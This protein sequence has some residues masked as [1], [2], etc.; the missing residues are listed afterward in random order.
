MFVMEPLLA[1]NAWAILRKPQATRPS[2]I[3]TVAG[4]R[5]DLSGIFYNPAVM[6]TSRRKEVFAFGEVVGM[7]D[8]K[9]GGLF[10]V[11]PMGMT[12]DHAIGGGFLS[13]DAGTMDLYYYGS[14]GLKS[15][16]ISLERDYVVFLGYSRKLNKAKSLFVGF[17]IEFA[18]SSIVE[19]FNSYALAA[20]FALM[21][22]PVERRNLI[23]SLSM[24]NVGIPLKAFYHEKEPLPVVLTPGISYSFGI[25][26]FSAFH[27][28]AAFSIDGSTVLNPR[29]V[30]GSSLFYLGSV[31]PTPGAGLEVGLLKD[32]RMFMTLDLGYRFNISDANFSA[33]FTFYPVERLDVGI[34]YTCSKYLNP[35]Y[36]VSIGFRF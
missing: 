3:T 34:A 5:G 27:L 18:F 17:S 16:T 30:E 31:L 29:R 35:S 1:I 19:R 33:G 15:A 26:R 2:A 11:T 25:K 14:G 13:Y 24:Q 7:A 20:D 32:Y 23:F 6:V 4:V 28:F 8:D 10:F 21:Y 36:R 12:K 9:Y 22:N